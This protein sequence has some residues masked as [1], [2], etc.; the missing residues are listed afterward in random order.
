MR[1]VVILLFLFG[2]LYV[3]FNK[4][5]SS[6][7]MRWQSANRA[8][9]HQEHQGKRCIKCHEYERP[10]NIPPHGY[11]RDCR[12]CHSDKLTGNILSWK[13]VNRDRVACIDDS[14]RF[15]KKIIGRGKVATCLREHEAELSSKC[16]DAII[17]LRELRERGSDK[18]QGLR[19]KCAKDIVAICGVLGVDNVSIVKCLMKNQDMI[20][21]GCKEIL[22]I[23]SK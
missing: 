9:N 19:D 18:L 1:L 10:K 4:R 15:C 11:N 17:N 21:P 2:A 14:E 16:R 23:K 7:L 20:S 8:F 6:R 22:L 5:E 3:F 13:K 12:G